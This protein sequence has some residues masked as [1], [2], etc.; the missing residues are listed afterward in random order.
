MPAANNGAG[1]CLRRMEK[2]ALAPN[3]SPTPCE[4][5][6]MTTLDER[7][8]TDTLLTDLG[9]RPVINLAGS[10]SRLG[11]TALARGVVQAMAAASRSFVPLV[12]LQAWASAAIAEATGADAGCIA[13]G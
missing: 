2:R 11:G 5:V 9:L 10:V 1:G 6:A 3:A 4:D 7:P 13:S 8:Q 12:E